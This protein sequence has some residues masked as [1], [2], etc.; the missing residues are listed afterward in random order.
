MYDSAYH[1]NNW[2]LASAMGIVLSAVACVI[3]V[4]YYRVT[5]GMRHAFGGEVR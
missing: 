3:L 2:G 5:A 4:V 1:D